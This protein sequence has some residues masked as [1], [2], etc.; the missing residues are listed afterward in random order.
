LT[1]SM[2]P[3]ISPGDTVVTTGIDTDA[4]CGLAIGDVIVFL[5]YPDDPTL[6]T[7]RIVAKSVTRAGCSF[8]TRGDNNNSD[9][10]WNPVYDFQIRGKVL[11]VVPKI[12]WAQH[13]VST[14]A[15]WVPAAIGVGLIGYA[16]IAFGR[17]FRRPAESPLE[18]PDD[19]PSPDDAEA[20]SPGD[21]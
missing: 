19:E 1:G 18:V 21:A 16:V 9:D 15:A 7:H 13:W 5:P 2:R 20:S 11:Y 6:V 4:A 3:T 12:G 8:T 10:S 14:H 17:T